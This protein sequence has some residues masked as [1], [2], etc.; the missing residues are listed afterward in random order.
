[1][2]L[3][4]SGQR[5]GAIVGETVDK[6]M[7]D[8]I[9]IVDWSW[10]MSA[11]SAVDGRRAGRVAMGA[12]RIVK[13]VD[14]ASTAFMAVMNNNELMPKVVLSCR[15]AGGTTPLVYFVLTLDQARISAY[16]VCSEATA[17]GTPMLTEHVSMTFKTI[18]IDYTPQTGAGGASGASSF[19]GQ[20]GID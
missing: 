2:F 1:M 13:R 9:D 17:E 20:A 3:K 19:T 12:L 10:A 15:K 18:T 16:E 5:T 7:P 4:A 14:K 8:Q 11:P 6:A